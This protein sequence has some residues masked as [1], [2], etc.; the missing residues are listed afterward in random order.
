MLFAGSL[1]FQNLSLSC[2][3][4]WCSGI[5]S[6]APDICFNNK[7][8][9]ESSH[10]SEFHNSLVALFVDQDDDLVEVMMLLLLLFQETH[11]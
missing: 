8:S 10:E 3:S 11:Q 2:V 9:K 7:S 6:P 5:L 4:M 1:L